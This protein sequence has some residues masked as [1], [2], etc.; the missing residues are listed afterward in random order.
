[1][2]PIS[3]VIAAGQLGQICADES[4]GEVLFPAEIK[5]K[6]LPDRNSQVWV[7]GRLNQANNIR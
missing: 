6:S 7:H 5:D 4:K 1:M 3:I 2:P